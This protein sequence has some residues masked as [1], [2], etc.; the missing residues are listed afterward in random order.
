[1]TNAEM[2]CFL[3]VILSLSFFAVEATA[4]NSNDYRRVG[5]SVNAGLTLPDNGG[6]GQLLGSNF[7]GTTNTTYNLGAGVSYDITPMWTIYGGYRY[8]EIEGSG[9][10]LFT[11]EV[12]SA[13]L[14]ARINFSRLFRRSSISNFLNPY[15]IIGAEQDFYS[16][17]SNTESFSSNSS[18]VIAGTGIAFRISDT[19]DLFTQYEVKFSSNSLDNVTEGVPFDQIG[20]LSA[21][22]KINF[23]KKG[24]KPLRMY[25]PVKRLTDIEYQEFKDKVDDIDRATEGVARQERTL[26]DFANRYERDLSRRDSTINELSKEL[27]RAH[28]RIDDLEDRVSLLENRIDSLKIGG[29]VSV[30]L[31]TVASGHYI[32]V[33]AARD[34]ES[35]VRVRDEMQ[36]QLKERLTD[37]VTVFMIHRNGFYE[38]LIGTFEEYQTASEINNRT[39]Q[40]FDDSF[41]ITFPRPVHLMEVYNDTHV[42]E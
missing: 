40:T 12:H 37:G 27:A 41:V 33:F 30:R 24:S 23:G 9:S 4:Q 8:N 11:T 1:M 18:S 28:T 35:S 20:M 19:F 2:R 39:V 13:S 34:L 32:Q 16:F 42:I 22:I 36:R 10:T 14:Q 38:V 29:D 6:G 26:R 15:G 31:K 7:S 21:G 3:G 25:P 17:S 5:F